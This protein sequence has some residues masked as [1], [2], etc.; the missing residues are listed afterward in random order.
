M[1]SLDEMTRSEAREVAVRLCFAVSE[2]PRDPEELLSETFDGE[3]Y[4]S[5]KTEDELYGKRPGE[6]Q[7]GYI[8]RIVKGTYEHG[9]ELD[10][11]IQKYAVGW[12]FERISRI[13]VAIIKTAMYEVLYM[14]DVPPRAAINE[15]IE[16]GKRYEPPE[17]VAFINGVLGS[18]TREE[19]AGISDGQ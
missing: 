9:P 5:L 10:G 3:Y 13:A 16:I 18:F 6:D 4:A 17:T 11:Y 19:T 1:A 12:S 14:P 8:R 2:N 7:I 15:A